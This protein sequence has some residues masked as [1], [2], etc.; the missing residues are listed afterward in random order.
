VIDCL[1]YHIFWEVVGLERGPFGLVST[2]EELLARKSNCSSLESRNYGRRDLPLWLRNTPPS[3]KVGINFA[4]KRRPRWG[5]G[6]SIPCEPAS[7]WSL[8]HTQTPVQRA[9]DALLLGIKR[10]MR[11]VNHWSHVVP[12]L[13]RYRTLFVCLMTCRRPI[14]PV[15][16][17]SLKIT[18][19]VLQR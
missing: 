5:V 12:R 10:S 9:L 4:D 3:A 15:S 13:R 1:R 2:I 7:S 11:K 19:C 6:S 16:N 17:C 18:N 8:W 14:L